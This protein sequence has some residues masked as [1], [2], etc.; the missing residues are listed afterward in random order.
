[1]TILNIC[2]NYKSIIEK[3]ITNNLSNINKLYKKSLE[4]EADTRHMVSAQ[5]RYL[6]AVDYHSIQFNTFITV[7]YSITKYI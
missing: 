7:T 2:K 5:N 6:Y 1:M 4:I 3:K